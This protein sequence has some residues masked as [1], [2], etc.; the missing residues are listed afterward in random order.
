[1]DVLLNVPFQKKVIWDDVY[2]VILCIYDRNEY[3][4]ARGPFVGRHIGRT[5]AVSE[6]STAVYKSRSTGAFFTAIR[7]P[8]DR[9]SRSANLEI[10]S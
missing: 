5:P 6:F 8:S 3:P 4:E 1:M 2:N 9:P 7:S 10:P